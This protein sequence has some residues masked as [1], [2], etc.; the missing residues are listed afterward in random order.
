VQYLAYGERW[1]CGRCGRTW[2]TS[3]I[4]E[5]DYQAIKRIQRRYAAVPLAVFAVVLATC[6]L[7]MVFGRVYA[8]ILLPVALT[9]WFMFIRPLQRRR[10]RRRIAELPEWK[11]EPE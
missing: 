1:Q 8:I 6:I 11:L 2:D 5:Q 7:F 10:M 9:F 3:R 4:P